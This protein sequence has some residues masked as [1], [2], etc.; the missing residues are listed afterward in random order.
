[1]AGCTDCDIGAS[2]VRVSVQSECEHLAADLASAVL[3]W[4]I[5]RNQVKP[6]N[7]EGKN[8]ECRGEGQLRDVD[9]SFVR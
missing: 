3:L 7:N 5:N 4:E 2:S 8:V 6:R 1:M 9:V